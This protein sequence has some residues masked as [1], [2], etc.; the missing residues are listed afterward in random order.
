MMPEDRPLQER[1]LSCTFCG[2]GTWATWDVVTDDGVVFVCDRHHVE[3]SQAK[4]I[5]LERRMGDATF[6]DIKSHE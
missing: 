5:L 2:P 1:E 6:K 3:M 4:M